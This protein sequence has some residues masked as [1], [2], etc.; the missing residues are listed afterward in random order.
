MFQQD[1]IMREVELISRFL[2]K[3]LL[4]RDLEQQE[5]TVEFE[6]L[7]ENYFAYRLRRLV[8]EGKINQ[9]ENELFEAMEEEPKMEYLSAAFEFYRTLAELDPVYLKQCGFSEEEIA[10]G[11]QD[12]KRIYGIE[13]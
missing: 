5:E 6:C 2:A 8:G 9:A 11:L 1:F 3:T 4:G 10:E 12:V 7:S 13:G